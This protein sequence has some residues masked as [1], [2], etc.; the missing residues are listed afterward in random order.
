MALTFCAQYIAVCEWY[1][2]CWSLLISVNS[3]STWSSYLLL[4]AINSTWIITIL[5]NTIKQRQAWNK[6]GQISSG[7]YVTHHN[8]RYL[9]RPGLF[10]DTGQNTR[11]VLPKK[12]CTGMLKGFKVH[13]YSF[14]Y[15]N[16]VVLKLFRVY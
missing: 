4:L 9:C 6:R 15:T 3:G 1:C 10:W 11:G 8:K 13:F 16:G 5:Y 7:S 2:K 12:W 14:W